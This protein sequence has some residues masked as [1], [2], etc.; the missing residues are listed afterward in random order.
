MKIC[1]P[2]LQTAFRD[3][4]T[5]LVHF[6]NMNG[7]ISDDVQSQVLNVRS[8]LAVNDKTQMLVEGIRRRVSQKKDSYHELV[9]GLSRGG[10]HYE[11]IVKKLNEEYQRQISSSTQQ[12]D[13]KCVYI[14]LTPHPML[15]WLTQTIDTIGP[16]AKD[17]KQFSTRCPFL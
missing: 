5:K 16:C 7:F 17:R 9:R 1:D 13:G 11:P 14:S 4:E 2:S 3:L 15:S 8:V 12:Q 10:V 6:L